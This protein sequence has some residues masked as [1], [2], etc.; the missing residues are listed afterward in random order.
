[1]Y[2]APTVILSEAKDPLKSASRDSSA[3]PQND[4]LNVL[5]KWILAKLNLLVEDVTEGMENYE[6]VKAS[7]P[8]VEF[9]TELSQWYVRRSR[10][11][12]KEQGVR[13]KE[14]DKL[15]AIATL[16]E[17]LLTLSKVM[18]PFTPFLA[19]K[20]YL[21]IVNSKQTTVN[22]KESVHLEEWPAFAKATSGDAQ[23]LES[24]EKARKVVELGLALRAEVGIK[25]KQPLA[26][27]TINNEQLTS[28][29]KMIVADELNVKEVVVEE[30]K[31]D[32]WATKEDGGI[33]VALFTEISPTLKAEGT[34]RE[35][36]RAI[37]Q[38]RKD[39]GL[40]ISNSVRVKYQTDNPE[41]LVVLTDHAEYIKKSVLADSLEAGR[42]DGGIEVEVGGAKV[43][44]SVDK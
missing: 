22:S 12:F 4:S 19:E 31:G 8:I 10:D 32:S 40:S 3:M 41:L 16:R 17:V 21:E 18:A 23:V 44:L 34:A 33:K 2:A 29:L 26:K 36:V 28:E 25:V 39:Q 37:N 38:I 9:V 5:D 24:M 13:N 6:L 43:W 7:R 15:S 35:I 27:L 14:Q 20:V 30:V 11:R 1:M 42:A